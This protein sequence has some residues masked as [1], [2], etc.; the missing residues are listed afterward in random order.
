[1]PVFKVSNSEI[2]V[3]CNFIENIMPTLNGAYVKIYLYIL[4]LA[5]KGERADNSDIAT[6]L[7]LLESD[8]VH[9]FGVLSEQGL[10]DV[11]GDIVSIGGSVSYVSEE[12]SSAAADGNEVKVSYSTVDM[13]EE[14]EKN[15]SLADMFKLAQEVMGKPLNSSDTNTLFWFYDKLGFSPEVILLLLE[16]CVS[17][18]K[19]NMSYIEKVAISWR[20]KGIKTIDDV[21]ML[22]TDEQ[23]RASYISNIKHLIGIRDRDLTKLEEKF[24]L[25]WREEDNM[26]EEMVALAYEYCMLQTDKR[27]FHYMNGIIKRWKSSGIFTIEAAERDNESFRTKQS[28]VPDTS[29]S[30]SYSKMERRM[31]DNMK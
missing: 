14:I 13:S 2:S 28:A 16:Y 17:A 30:D 22:E 23:E 20:E 29:A 3:S 7:G 10:I 4:M 1:M 25:E 19:R 31:W 9:A 6:K 18:G 24:L 27:S 11:S 5:N 12:A 26:S 21:D 15:K 8:V